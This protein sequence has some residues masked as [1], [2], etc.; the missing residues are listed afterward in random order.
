MSSQIGRH[1]WV[2]CSDSSHSCQSHSSNQS[3]STGSFSRHTPSR[4]ERN[5]DDQWQM[6][7]PI[8][9]FSPQNWLCCRMSCAGLVMPT[10]H[11]LHLMQPVW[12]MQSTQPQLD[13]GDER[14]ELLSSFAPCFPVL[15]SELTHGHFDGDRCSNSQNYP[16]PLIKCAGC[17]SNSC[18]CGS[19]KIIDTPDAVV[20]VGG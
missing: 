8:Q 16:R 6:Q 20:G 12:C 3:E 19:G 4:D 7:Y 15:K 2:G 13:Y 10:L 17:G 9:R 5:A 14:G 18:R 11:Q 1:R